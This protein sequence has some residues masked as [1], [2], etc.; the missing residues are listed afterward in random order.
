MFNLSDFL[1]LFP[2]AISLGELAEATGQPVAVLR[3]EARRLYGDGALSLYAVG[4]ELFVRR[5]PAGELLT[6]AQAAERL[7]VNASRVR[8]LIAAGRLD[9]QKPGRDWVI[10][11]Y[12]LL[13][14]AERKPGRPAR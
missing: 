8:A 13:D 12:A 1:P 3:D 6:A 7:G 4:A 2:Q 11:E 14:V 10:P 9:A 5:E